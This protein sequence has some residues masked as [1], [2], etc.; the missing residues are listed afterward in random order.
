M[1]TKPL[2][3]SSTESL[4]LRTSPKKMNCIQSSRTC[5][6]WLQAT[7]T[8]EEG[9]SLACN[10]SKVLFQMFSR[11][12][13]LIQWQFSAAQVLLLLLAQASTCPVSSACLKSASSWQTLW[14]KHN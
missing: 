1:G 12:E 10:S 3:G 11:E 4:P 6:I 5:L 9:F 2:W 8:A 13:D 7:T 14:V